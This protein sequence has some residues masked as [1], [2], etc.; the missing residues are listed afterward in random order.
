MEALIQIAVPVTE[1]LPN[2]V[3]VNKKKISMGGGE[4]GSRSKEAFQVLFDLQCS[5]HSI[6]Q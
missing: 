5:S 2:T 3:T 6:S 4:D 1:D